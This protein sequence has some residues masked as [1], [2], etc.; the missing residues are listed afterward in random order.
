MA[1]IIGKKLG[2]TQIFAEDGE[3]IAVTIVE[4]L[5]FTVMAHLSPEV[6]GASLVQVASGEVKEA[7]VNKPDAGQFKKAGI[8]PAKHISTFRDTEASAWELGKVYGVSIFEGDKK[9]TVIGTGKGK[10]FQGTVKRYNFS[11]GP[12]SHGSHNIR[13]PGSLGAH[14]YPARV[15]PGKKLPGHMGDH[16]VTTKN[17]EIVKMDA[18][19][20]LLY[21][22]GSVPGCINSKVIVRK[23]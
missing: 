23:Q 3:A 13:A 22:R 12:T 10:G 16:R 8:A 7:F 15:F 4:A 2:M 18:E 14:S 1:E 17:L 20:N 21:L 11:R 6:H 9:V 19:K 5:P